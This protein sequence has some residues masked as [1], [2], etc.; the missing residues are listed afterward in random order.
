MFAMQLIEVMVAH[1]YMVRLWS[2][3]NAFIVQ[4]KGSHETWL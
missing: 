2:C 3:Q 1:M 4:L